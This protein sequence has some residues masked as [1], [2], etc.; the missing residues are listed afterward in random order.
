MSHTFPV[1]KNKV[2]LDIGYEMIIWVDLWVHISPTVNF[3]YNSLER[4]GTV[5]PI[6]IRA[7]GRVIL[8]LSSIISERR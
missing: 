2:D 3:K 6:K 5:V 7:V 8:I 1:D 4:Y